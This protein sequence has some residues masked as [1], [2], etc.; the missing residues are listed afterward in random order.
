MKYIPQL[1][2]FRAIACLSVLF[3]HGDV[4]YF[5]Y[6]WIGV[7]MFFVLSG[8]LITGILVDSTNS[9]HYFRN[10]FHRR[11][12]RIFPIYYLMFLCLFI[13]GWWLKQPLMD[14]FWYFVWGQNFI[15]GFTDF[16]AAFP[17]AYNHTWSLAVEQQF[18]LFWPLIIYYIRNKIYLMLL[19]IALFFCSIY[20]RYCISLYVDLAISWTVLVS[21]LD[22]LLA[23]A[24]VAVALRS[25]IEQRM[26]KKIAWLVL[27]ASVIGYVGMI[28][29]LKLTYF[30]QSKLSLISHSGQILLG[31]L[32]PIFA[33]III[34]I[35][36]STSILGK[37]LSF[38]AFRYIG[39]ISYGLYLYH[40][41]IYI[42]GEPLLKRMGIENFIMLLLLKLSI[43]FLVAV[44]SWHFLERRVLS[45]EQKNVK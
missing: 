33:S 35:F 26:L 20:S 12:L 29:S 15:L 30:W 44:I 8:F 3:F 40:Y 23:G 9:E 39:K 13:V 6:G 5:S 21:N 18:Y 2:S 31:F 43:T 38:S 25:D 37:V 19:I 7:Q 11:I 17:P 14:A 34:L 36:K 28:Y 45:L 32:G 16:K 24:I 22:T 42:Y 27:I 4:S 41:P 1:D 10:F